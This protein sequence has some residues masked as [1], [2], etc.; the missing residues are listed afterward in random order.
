MVSGGYIASYRRGAWLV[1]LL[2]LVLWVVSGETTA[3]SVSQVSAVPDRALP[4]TFECHIYDL[5]LRINVAIQTSFV[6]VLLLNWEP[7][8]AF[9]VNT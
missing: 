5:D 6:V 4:I 3:S 9:V 7:I 8:T 2:V 1:L